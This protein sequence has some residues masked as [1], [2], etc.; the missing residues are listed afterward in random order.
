M[1][2]VRGPES[3]KRHSAWLKRQEREWRSKNG[4]II[5]IHHDW[6]HCRYGDPC[7]QEKRRYRSGTSNGTRWAA[8][9]CHANICQPIWESPAFIKEHYRVA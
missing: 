5:I 2:I 3:A 1:S 9:F 7:P 4:P 8:W 6:P